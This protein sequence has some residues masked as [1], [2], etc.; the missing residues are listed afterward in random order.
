LYTRLNQNETKNLK[1][2]STNTEERR[3]LAQIFNLKSVLDSSPTHPPSKIELLKLDFYYMNYD[4][5][6]HQMYSNEQTSTAMAIFDHVFNTMQEKLLKPEQ[7]LKLLR[8]IL[9]VHTI[10]RPPFSILIFSEKEVNALVDYSLKTYLRHFYLYEYAFKP[11]VELVLRTDLIGGG[12][13]M[14]SK[15]VISQQSHSNDDQRVLPDGLGG[16]DITLMTSRTG[17]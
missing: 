5:C 6:K 3:T 8:Q 12:N 7:G 10:Q 11:K 4:F 14:S 9:D 17:D 13:A 15:A 1:K 2:S 16:K